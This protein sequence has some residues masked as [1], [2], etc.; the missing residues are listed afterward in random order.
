MFQ[1][2]SLPYLLQSLVPTKG[3]I[4]LPL[5]PR[6][7][8]H[9]YPS[10]CKSKDR[11]CTAGSERTCY[12]YA[13]KEDASYVTRIPQNVQKN[14][15]VGY[16]ARQHAANTDVTHARPCVVKSEETGYGM[17]SVAEP[18]N[19][20]GYGV[21]VPVQAIKTEGRLIKKFKIHV[22]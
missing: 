18:L 8:V 3:A 9:H 1:V 10:H 16:G 19:D 20:A 17:P 7:T 13:T 14:N 5:R 21:R 22:Q 11:S 15:T 4:C 12:Q 2:M 6:G